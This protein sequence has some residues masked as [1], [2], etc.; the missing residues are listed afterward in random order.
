MAFLLLEGLSSTI[1]CVH[2]SIFTYR[3]QLGESYY[4]RYDPELG[5][6][7]TPGVRLPNFFGPGIGITI[8]SQGLRGQDTAIEASGFRIVCSGDSFTF[9]YGVDDEHAWCSLLAKF[10]K[11]LQSV[12]MGQG[13][14]GIDQASSGTC[15]MARSSSIRC[16][17]L[18]S[19]L[20]IFT[21]CDTDGSSVMP[22]PC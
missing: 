5:W 22:N 12:N 8:N 18:L 3:G 21:V 7:S 9:G 11:R 19:S 20:W 15:A 13:G 1:L 4:T 2:D 10:D 14:Y 6:A 17:S 16:T